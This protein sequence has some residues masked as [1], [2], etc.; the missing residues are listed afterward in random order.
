MSMGDRQVDPAELEGDELRRWYLRTPD[1]I[2]HERAQETQ[3]RRDAF[4]GVGSVE[5]VRFLRPPAPP[6]VMVRPAPVTRAAYPPGAPRK[7]GARSSFFGSYAPLPQSNTYV[8]RL[9][10]P[11][12]RVEQTLPM[13]GM[14]QL[15]DGTMVSGPEV[16]RIYAEQK[17]RIAGADSPEPKSRVRA[18]NR[19][20][21]G[22]I[23]L[24]S[25]LEK[26][27]RELDPT[28][29]PNGGWEHDPGFG[30]RS[31]RSRRFET[32]VTGATAL[33]Y[34]VRNPG[35]APVK[36]D[37]CAVSSPRHELLEAKGPGYESII[38][39]G[40]R[41]RFIKSIREGA[42]SQGQRQVGAAGGRPLDWYF[43]E[44]GAL[45]F[46]KRHIPLRR[47]IQFIHTP[48]R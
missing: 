43:A 34:V 37:G 9:P 13:P 36:F 18:V 35:K 10:A 12:D 26:G 40:N 11:L 29:H 3:S 6:P 31:E 22:Q 19:W 32:Q 15:S 42:K 33:D 20:K 30:K 48:A 41:Y 38:D 2:E 46:F 1:E 27:E 28:C 39:A 45:E 23:P 5:K 44:Q 8:Q 14:Y 21:D 17:R 47:R 25:Q 4:F 16:D 24:A 7:A